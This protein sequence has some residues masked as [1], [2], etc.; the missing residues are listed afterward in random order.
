MIIIACIFVAAFRGT[1]VKHMRQTKGNNTKQK[2]I[3][4]MFAGTTV[5]TRSIGVGE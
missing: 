3:I 2:I 4:A 1:K 5:L